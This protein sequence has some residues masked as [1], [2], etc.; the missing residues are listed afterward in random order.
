MNQVIK[1]EEDQN[2]ISLYGYLLFKFDMLNPFEYHQNISK[3]DI[4]I[5]LDCLGDA[6]YYCIGDEANYKEVYNKIYNDEKYQNLLND[7]HDKIKATNLD[8]DKLTG[9]MQDFLNRANSANND[10][11]IRLNKIKQDDLIN[12]GLRCVD[13]TIKNYLK[14]ILNKAF[15]IFMKNTNDKS[16][17][18]NSV[19]HSYILSYNKILKDLT[20]TIKQTNIDEKEKCSYMIDIAHLV[21]KHLK[22]VEYMWN[23]KDKFVIKKLKPLSMNSNVG[24]TMNFVKFSFSNQLDFNDD[25]VGL[26]ALDKKIALITQ[27]HDS[28]MINDVD[29]GLFSLKMFKDRWI[30]VKHNGYFILLTKNFFRRGQ[31]ESNYVKFDN[32]IDILLQIDSSQSKLTKK[33]IYSVELDIYRYFRDYID[34]YINFDSPYKLIDA[35]LDH[36]L[37]EKPKKY[38]KYHGSYDKYK[39]FIHFIKANHYHNIGEYII[40]LQKVFNDIAYKDFQEAAKRERYFN[41][42]GAITNRLSYLWQCYNLDYDRQTSDKFIEFMGKGF[43]FDKFIDIYFK[44]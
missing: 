43:N 19:I 33:D 38:T 8:E 2:Y 6:T 30:S 7:I 1:D 26:I 32:F 11:I 20:T 4:K 15:I 36:L 44:A 42:T 39:D 23:L 13:K 3:D 5:I 37:G 28:V 21:I 29:M 34:E 25:F 24:V 16:P 27:W 35:I 17:Q 12:F 18:K 10:F 22:T 14:E 41:I 40:S 31:Y 9:F